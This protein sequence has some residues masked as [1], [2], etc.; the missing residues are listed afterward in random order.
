M[1]RFDPQSSRK[2]LSAIFEVDK[3]PESLET[4]ILCFV[5]AATASGVIQ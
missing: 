1:F 2:P 4:A 3:G 5:R